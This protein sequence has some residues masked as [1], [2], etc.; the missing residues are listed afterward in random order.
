MFCSEKSSLDKKLIKIKKLL[1]EEYPSSPV[2]IS[3]HLIY[4]NMAK[5]TRKRV[6][7]R[8][9]TLKVGSPDWVR[10]KELFSSEDV[11][12][13]PLFQALDFIIRNFKKKN[14]F[15]D[16]YNTFIF[17]SLKNKE[18]HCGVLFLLREYGTVYLAFREI[19][20]PCKCYFE[21]PCYLSK[22]KN[23]KPSF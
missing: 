11:V 1:K 10:G 7:L 16:D 5:L 13:L 18:G 23:K 22:T 20:N 8:G 6:C 14:F 3:S 19:D 17:V 4:F 2:S 21:A 9:T 15:D 12:F